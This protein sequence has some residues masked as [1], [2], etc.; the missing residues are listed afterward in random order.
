MSHTP[1]T[2][3]RAAIEEATHPAALRGFG[4][5]LIT[6]GND[7]ATIRFRDVGHAYAWARYAGMTPRS[8]IRTP[9]AE[10][11]LDVTVILQLD[12]T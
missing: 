10:M 8:L 12:L 3:E 1:I 7:T 11:S 6:R 9:G 4:G 2:D 5:R